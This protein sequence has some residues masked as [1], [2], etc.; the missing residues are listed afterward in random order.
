MSR[1]NNSI[2]RSILGIV[3]GLLLIIWPEVAITYLVIMIG[4]FFI[5]PGLYALI[6]YLFRD[7]A[8]DTYSGMFPVISIGS[9]LLGIWL[10]VMPDFFVGTFMYLLGILLIIAGIQQTYYLIKAR[11]WS[12]VSYLFFI[13]PAIIFIIGIMILV[14]PFG[15]AK[16]TFIIF[17]VASL[18]YGIN[19]MINWIK[20]RKKKT[21]QPFIPP[22]E[23]IDVDEEL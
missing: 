21:Q 20:F 17:G 7:K 4:I 3:L 5:I 16:N 6:T 23:I 15:A 22:T 19:E 18:L 9:I 12:H 13:L 1:F 8:A 2:L 14:Y 10:V 11:K